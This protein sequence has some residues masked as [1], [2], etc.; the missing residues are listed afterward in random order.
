MATQP[1]THARRNADSEAR[2]H[3]AVVNARNKRIMILTISLSLLLILVAGIITGVYLLAQ[4][5]KVD[6]KILD[7]V[8]VG[9]V[10]IGGMTKE[11]AIITAV[12]FL[13]FFMMI[14]RLN[15]F[16]TA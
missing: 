11:D 13:R 12:S 10:N 7:N 15:C 14:S 4:N 16:K 8:I 6:D 1:N 2:R 9:G 5:Q 3:L